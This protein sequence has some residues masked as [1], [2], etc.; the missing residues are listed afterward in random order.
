MT[1]LPN[2]RAVRP[3]R[4]VCLCGSTRFLGELLQAAMDET[5]A[6]RIVVGP[7]LFG[8]ADFPP[9]ARQVTADGDETT[10]IKQT[11]DALHYRKIDL[12]DEILVVN[13]A[14]YIGTSTQREIEYARAM[15]KTIRYLDGERRLRE[16][17]A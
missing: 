12:A 17:A 7:N 5:L 14:G 10:E 6:G 16:R 3:P 9:G 4:I 13:V 15:G 1:A 2:Q 11:L 8:H